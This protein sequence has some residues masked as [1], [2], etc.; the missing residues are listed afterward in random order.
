MQYI[1][2]QNIYKLCLLLLEIIEVLGLVVKNLKTFTTTF[3]RS[4]TSL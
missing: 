1:E 2:I 3:R 4:G